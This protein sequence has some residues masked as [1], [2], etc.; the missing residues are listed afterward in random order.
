MAE[1]QPSGGNSGPYPVEA[2]FPINGLAQVA[3]FA[4]QEAGTSPDMLN[5][6]PFD[7]NGRMR[8]SSRPGLLKYSTAQVN[9]SASVQC[10][11]HVASTYVA[12]ILGDGQAVSLGRVAAATPGFSYWSAAAGTETAVAPANRTYLCSAFGANGS[13]YVVSFNAADNKVYFTCYTSA[14]P[15]TA[16]YEVNVFTATALP[17]NTDVLGFTIDED[18]FYLWYLK[19]TGIGEGIMRFKLSNGSNRDSSTKGVW[20]RGSGCDLD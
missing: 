4:N 16:A 13:L 20:I 3:P 15:T 17:V 12:P 19:I 14:A 5:V 10:L 7:A 11:S 1:Q 18:T 9:G 6:F 8:G 2:G